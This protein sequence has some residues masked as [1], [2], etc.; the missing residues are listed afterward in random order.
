MSKRN[1]PSWLKELKEFALRGNVMDLA[2]GVIIGGAFQ[3]IVSSLVGDVIS[4]IIGLFGST[5]F[6][7]L[8]LTL[9]EGVELRYGAFITAV[10]NF[11]IMVVVIFA[12]VKGV[13]RLTHLRRHEL[14]EEAAEE[15]P[16]VKACPYCLSEIPAAATRCPHCTSE[17]EKPE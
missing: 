9:K 8:T 6:S 15:T 2:V 13:N 12:L 11:L 4:P 17:L 5:D 14:A 3:A 10:L 16:A 7:D 1:P